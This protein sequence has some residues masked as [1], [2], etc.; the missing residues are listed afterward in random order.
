MTAAELRARSR[1]PAKAVGGQ[2][3]SRAD[4]APLRDIGLDATSGRGDQYDIGKLP[5]LEYALEQAWAKR[6]RAGSALAT[7]R[8]G[9]GARGAR[10]RSLRPALSPEQQAAAKRLFVSLVTPGEGREDT[11]ARITL[12]GSDPSD[13]GSGRSLRRERCPPRRHRRMPPARSA[14]VSHEALIRHWDRL[15]AWI[16]ENRANLRTRAALVADRAEW[17]KQ[18]RHPQPAHRARPAAGSGAQAARPARRRPDRRHQGLHRGLHRGAEAADS[19]QSETWTGGGCGDYSPRGGVGVV[20]YRYYNQLVVTRP[21]AT[22][23]SV[24]T[25]RRYPLSQD[26]AIVG[27]PTE[28]PFQQVGLSDEFVSRLHMIIFRNFNALDLRSLNG[29]TINGEFLPYFEQRRL[30]DGDA[31][32]LAGVAAFL[33]RPL[34]HQ[35]WQF[36]WDEPLL[37]C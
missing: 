20:L 13:A 31:I 28:S 27:R 14:E 19:S 30:M 7:M 36:L 32:V 1:G 21:W 26:L 4:Q 15:R 37:L 33:F 2:R 10:Q 11:R 24:V 6:D 17:L 3:A 22:L 25:G 23:D 18:G 8:A 35:P 34:T 12:H 9:A 16:D 29:T 5:L